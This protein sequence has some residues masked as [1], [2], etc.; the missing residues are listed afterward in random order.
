MNPKASSPVPLLGW[1][2]LN[3]SLHTEGGP[4]LAKIISSSPVKCG[5]IWEPLARRGLQSEAQLAG[6]SKKHFSEVT[7]LDAYPSLPPSE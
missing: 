4:A 1:C 2:D 6:L 7:V 5:S 3:Q